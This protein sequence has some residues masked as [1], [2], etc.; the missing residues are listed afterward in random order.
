MGYSSSESLK[1]RFTSKERD[2]ETGLDYFGARYFASVQGRF[3]SSDPLLSSGTIY[4]PQSWNRYAYTLNNPL[5]YI[6]P[7]GLYVFA[8]GTDDEYKKR[9]R[10]GV[11]DLQK[12]R[13]SFKKGS[14]EYNR[15]NRSLTAYGR[16]GVNNGV[17]IA[18]G[19]TKDGAP[20]ATSIGVK[21]DPTGAK[22]T[23]ADNSTGQ[24][25]IV[26]IDPMKNKSAEDYVSSVGHEGSHVAD[27]SDLVSALPTDLTSSVAQTALNGALNLSKYVTETRAYEVTSFAA[28][29]RGAGILTIGT[30]KHEIWNAGWSQAD[31]ATKRRAGI[32]RVLADPVGY[33]KVTPK[34]QGRKLIE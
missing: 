14:N 5:K 1:Q 21:A 32:E 17:T 16:E 4:D 28:Q 22:L 23:T 25:T 15:L 3:A 13:D 12:A 33:Y 19:A 6:D 9:F 20:A 31:R 29:G 26:T 18:F 27:G 30:G 8:D 7:F 10:Q 24:D 11:K 2:S 34:D